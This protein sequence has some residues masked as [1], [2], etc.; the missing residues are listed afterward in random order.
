MSLLER[1]EV[2]ITLNTLKTIL[3]ALDITAS[4]FFAGID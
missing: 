2:N 1:G 4:K 3:D